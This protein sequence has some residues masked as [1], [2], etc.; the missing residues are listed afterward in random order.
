MTSMRSPH[1]PARLLALAVLLFATTVGTAQDPAPAP[2]D[3]S[4][5]AEIATVSQAF[6]T[7]YNAG[8]ADAIA[9]L[10]TEQGEFISVDGMVYQGRAAIREEFAASFAVA[11][12]EL[13][14][15]VT[16]VRLVAPN[17]AIEDGSATITPEAG[18]AVISNYCA[19]YVKQ[20]DQWMLA[21]LRDMESE[22]LNAGEN[23][24][25]LEWLIGNWTAETTDGVVEFNFDWSPDG[26]F[27]LGG[28][29]V[30]VDG[31]AVLNGNIRIGWDP[32][33]QQ[34]HDWIFDSVGGHQRSSWTAQS[35]RWM[36]I[37]KGFTH[38]GK[39]GSS[40]SYF[41]PTGDD[42]FTWLSTNRI[43]D[44]EDQGEVELKMVRQPPAPGSAIDNSGDQ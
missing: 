30:L 22:P 14:A 3:D 39:T 5:A 35:D 37:S 10:F 8:D 9:T 11:K 21:S 17:T 31:E 16:S 18:P 28:Y 15:E 29:N 20:N 36:V 23:L 42:Q 1:L 40:V 2:S 34:I 26:N 4:L 12:S 32:Q 19:V 41:I 38:D 13:T 33:Q 25:S 44:G 6:L 7:A 27:I 43:V 24:L